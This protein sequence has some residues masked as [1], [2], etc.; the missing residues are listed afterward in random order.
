ERIFQSP[1]AIV[2]AEVQPEGKLARR[3]QTRALIIGAMHANAALR[4]K[5]GVVRGA[6]P[7]DGSFPFPRE[8]VLGRIVIIARGDGLPWTVGVSA[9]IDAE[10]AGGAVEIVGRGDNGKHRQRSDAGREIE[11]VTVRGGLRAP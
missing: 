3:G 9:A 5:T 2:A 8:A 11:E 10:D 4:L 6:N 1:L 7:L